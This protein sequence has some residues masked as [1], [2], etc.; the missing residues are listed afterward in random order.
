MKKK[1]IQTRPL[2]PRVTD[3]FLVL[4]GDLYAGFLENADE[5]MILITLS[6]IYSGLIIHVSISFVVY[7]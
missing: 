1:I 6:E 2:G 3:L 4:A 7:S 5:V